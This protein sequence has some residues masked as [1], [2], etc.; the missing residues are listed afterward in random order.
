MKRWAKVTGVLGCLVIVLLVIA[1]LVLPSFVRPRS[2]SCRYQ[3][4][5]NLRQI[6]SAKEQA[7]LAHHWQEGHVPDVGIVNQYIKGNTTPVC[8]GQCRYCSQHW[9][10]AT[11]GAPYSYNPT[12]M[13]PTCNT[14][15]CAATHRLP[16]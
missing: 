12:G 7:A 3:C 5:N 14:K 9:W 6:E 2:H 15:G 1:A 4:I 8:L 16:E 11:K 10:Q 13:K